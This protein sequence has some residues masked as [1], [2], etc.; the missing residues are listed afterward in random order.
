[1]TNIYNLNNIYFENTKGCGIYRRCG[2]CFNVGPTSLV[3]IVPNCV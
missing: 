2:V 1:M 3:D